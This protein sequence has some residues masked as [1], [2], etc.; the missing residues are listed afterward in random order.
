MEFLAVAGLVACALALYGFMR[1]VSPYS[2]E[3]RKVLREIRSR[4][5]TQHEDP[6]LVDLMMMKDISQ[7]RRAID[8]RKKQFRAP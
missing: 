8:P 7:H 4:L 2:Y 1:S 5:T 6:E 3:Q